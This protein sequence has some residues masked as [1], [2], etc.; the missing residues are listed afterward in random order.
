MARFTLCLTFQLPTHLEAF[1]HF[2]CFTNSI[3]FLLARTLLTMAFFAA[4]LAAA[5]L[6]VALV[7]E[8]VTGFF[9]TEDEAT[10]GC[11]TTC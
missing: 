1:S 6:A 3:H 2:I 8:V 4:V 11:L 10:R 7:P 5:V 9:A